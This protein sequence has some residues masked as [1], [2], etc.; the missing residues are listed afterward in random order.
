MTSVI[1]A[2][3]FD[4]GGTLGDVDGGSLLLT[5]YPGSVDLVRAMKNEL[6]LRTGILTNAGTL[7]AKAVLDMLEA[8]GFGGLF[9]E[10]TVVTSAD[11]GV[12]KPDPAIYLLAASRVPLL[13]AECLFV[14]ENEGEVQGALRHVDDD[15]SVQGRLGR[16]VVEF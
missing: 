10:A 7:R 3:F 1:R 11:A 16:Q 15:R 14:G 9:D 5:P 12:A 8:A 6:G 13:P 2:V 4:I